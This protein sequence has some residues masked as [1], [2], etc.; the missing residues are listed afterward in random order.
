MFLKNLAR[1][2]VYPIKDPR[3]REALTIHE[4]PPPAIAEAA[5]GREGET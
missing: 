3:L 2:P 5:Q 1:H 4:V